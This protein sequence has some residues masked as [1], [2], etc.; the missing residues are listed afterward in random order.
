MEF[1]IIKIIIILIIIIVVVIII[2]TSSN[3]SVLSRK[4]FSPSH[5]NQIKHLD[6]EKTKFDN[7]TIKL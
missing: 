4:T 5:N 7:L 2:I 3:L 1:S 6:C